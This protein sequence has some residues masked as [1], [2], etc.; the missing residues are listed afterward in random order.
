MILKSYEEYSEIIDSL[1]EKLSKELRSSLLLSA[2]IELIRLSAIAGSISKGD[3]D[4]FVG[5]L[6]LNHLGRVNYE[7][8]P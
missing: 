4:V 7:N 3:L 2:R 5:V 6:G 1:F 8:P